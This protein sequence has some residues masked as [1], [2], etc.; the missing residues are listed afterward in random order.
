[1]RGLSNILSLFCKKFNTIIKE[2]ED[3]F[4]SSYDIKRTKITF[5]E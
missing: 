1:M 2:Q 4:Y 5:W 3:R